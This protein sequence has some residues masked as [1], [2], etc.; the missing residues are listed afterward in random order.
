MGGAFLSGSEPFMGAP[1]SF[2][3]I[4]FDFAHQLVDLDRH[5]RWRG[6]PCAITRG[7]SHAPTT[8]TTSHNHHRFM[9][10]LNGTVDRLSAVISSR[11]AAAILRPGNTAP[12]R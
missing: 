12:A 8:N 3:R 4:R 10:V 6:R 2:S 9:P 7:V 11:D 1:L 5:G